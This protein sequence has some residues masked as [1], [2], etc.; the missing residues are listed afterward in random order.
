MASKFFKKNF[1]SMKEEDKEKWN[2]ENTEYFNEYRKKI[3]GIATG[4]KEI[5]FLLKQFKE[6][7]E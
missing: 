7:N 5:E 1:K 4:D 3:L 2:K 6:E